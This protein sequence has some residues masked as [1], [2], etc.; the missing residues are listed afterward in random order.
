[1]S[2]AR[3]RVLDVLRE[4]GLLPS[5]QLEGTHMKMP[6][7][8]VRRP[9]AALVIACVALA[10]ALSP[11][12]YATVSQLLPTDSVGT[13]QLKADA[14]TS[15]KVRDFSLRKWDFKKGDLQGFVGDVTL[16][17][18]SITVPRGPVAHNGL[19]LTRV[20]QVRCHPG[21][22]AISGGTSWDSDKDGEELITVYSRPLMENGIPVGW[23]A[24]GGSDLGAARVFTVEALC[25]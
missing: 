7:L 22:R 14:V 5:V 3:A 10:I 11:A 4:K 2:L 13:P 24:R 25:L 12:S 15:N 16:R 8:R 18:S 19:Y 17:Q 1:M 21:E 20:I 6:H 23:R 9:S